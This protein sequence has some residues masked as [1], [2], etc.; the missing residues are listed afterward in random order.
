MP[1]LPYRIHGHIYL[2]NSAG[3]PVT[4]KNLNTNDVQTVTSNSDSTYTV[5]CSNFINGY[6]NG[7]IIQI[8]IQSNTNN[9][10]NNVTINTVNLTEI[11]LDFSIEEQ[12][13]KSKKSVNPVPTEYITTND[14]ITEISRQYEQYRLAQ[15]K[16]EQLKLEQLQQEQLQQ[17]QEQEQQ[18]KQ[19]S[20]INT[21]SNEYT[22]TVAFYTNPPGAGI[23][24]DGK[25]LINPL[26]GEA[27]ITPE[28]VILYKGRKNVVF[29]S[30]NPSYKN[31]STY[32]DV[33]PRTSVVISE[34]F[35]PNIEQRFN[36]ILEKF[37]Q[38]NNKFTRDVS[39]LNNSLASKIIEFNT[40]I[41]QKTDSLIKKISS[42]NN[43]K[44]E[45]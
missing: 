26:T 45:K 17:E 32:V 6:T 30:Q 27:K 4:A 44:I 34:Q 16:Q 22:G 36:N 21:I 14:L 5:D 39:Y 42:Y 28:T 20:N 15:L 29:T 24:I 33:F 10:A 25:P 1:L 13:L 31:I 12:P 40:E 3:I 38:Y 23:Y 43:F 2:S 18:L 19:L 8:T 7:D 35:Q 37:D 9:I 11:G 41:I